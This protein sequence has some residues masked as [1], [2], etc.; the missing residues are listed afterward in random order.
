MIVFKK[1][2]Y[3]NFLSTGNYFNEIVLDDSP[4]TLIMGKNGGGK[5][6]YLDAICFGLFGKAFRNINKGQLVNSIN[7]KGTLVEIEFSIGSKE[8]INL[9]LFQR[10]VNY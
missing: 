7:E 1:I 4:S 2:R 3:K 8:Y 6:T 5:S 10:F 9:P